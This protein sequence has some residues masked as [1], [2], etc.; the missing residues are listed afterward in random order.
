MNADSGSLLIV[1]DDGD[2]VISLTRLIKQRMG[3]VA[4]YGAASPVTALE[5][6][7]KQK[8]QVAI[9][10]LH[11]EAGR[12]VDAGFQL[13]CDLQRTDSTVRVIILTGHGSVEFGVK[14]LSLGAASFLEK[15][16]DIDHLCALARDAFAQSNL[17]RAYRDLSAKGE[18]S[19]WHFVGASPL[20]EKVREAVRYSA[21]TTQPILICGETGTGKG[22]VAHAIHEESGRAPFVRYQPNFATADLVNSELFGHLKGAFTG[23]VENRGGLLLEADGGTLFLD[24]I[25]ELPAEVQVT[26]LGVLQERKF[27]P[28][29]ANKEVTANFRLLCATNRDPSDAVASGKLRKDLYHRLAHTTIHIPPLRQRRE[30]VAILVQHFLGELETSHELALRGVSDQALKVLTSHDWPGNVRELYAVV[31]SAAFRAQF[32][33]S[34]WIEAEHLSLN[35]GGVAAAPATTLHDQVESFRR[36]VLTEVLQ[37]NE[38]NMLRTADELGLDRTSLRRMLRRLSISL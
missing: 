33:G 25:D 26:L 37:R 7:Q 22:L 11:L 14:A 13:L 21:R 24:E 27:R 3:G 17:R 18:P 5:I 29:G 30:D 8:P 19:Q 16:P 2:S 31:E 10:D 34:M 20:A 1:D 4:V 32:A 15:P 38:G 12:G 35:S 23:A 28:I 6:A 9:I 36:K